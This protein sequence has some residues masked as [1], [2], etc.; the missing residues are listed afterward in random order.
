MEWQLFLSLLESCSGICFCPPEPEAGAAVP[1][2]KIR[3]DAVRQS[4]QSQRLGQDVESERPPHQ[5]GPQL[6]ARSTWV[7]SAEMTLN[8]GWK[9]Y[10]PDHKGRLVRLKGFMTHDPDAKEIRRS[11]RARV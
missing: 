11:R 9:D 4:S 7:K 3:S 2:Q 10:R 8:I 5:V 6:S 1:G